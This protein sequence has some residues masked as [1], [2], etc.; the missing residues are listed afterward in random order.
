MNKALELLA[1]IGDL[2]GTGA[3][4]NAHKWGFLWQRFEQNG[5]A[6]YPYVGNTLTRTQYAAAGL[7]QFVS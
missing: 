6:Y 4:R 5:D 7:M 3:I 2:R 1:Y